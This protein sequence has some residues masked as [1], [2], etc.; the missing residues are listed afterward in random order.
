[1]DLPE[2]FQG[3]D[4][5]TITER[6]IIGFKGSQRK[7]LVVDDKWANRSVLVNL[8]EPLGFEVLE[9]TNGQEGLNKAIEVKPD[10]IL[11]DL[12]MTVMD[13]F[14][15]TRRLRMLPDFKQVVVIAISAS[16][17]DFD[18][19]QSREVGCDDFLPKPVREADLLEKLRVYLGLEWVYEES[20]VRVQPSATIDREQPTVDNEQLTNPR[21]IAPPAEELSILLDLAM[22]GNLRDIADRAT[23]LEELNEQWVPFATHLRQLAKGFKGKQILQFLKQLRGSNERGYY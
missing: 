21:L 18:K 15:A 1:L 6:N 2:V 12:V 11:M 7:V 5:A 19:Q 22:R 8:L 17:F 23:R 16:V 13:G 9:A 3:S 14:E 20:A 10:V 4:I